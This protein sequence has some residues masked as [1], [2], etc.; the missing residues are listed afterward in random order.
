MYTCIQVYMQD[1]CLTPSLSHPSLTPLSHTPLSCTHPSHS[2]F[3]NQERLSLI[4]RDLP[5]CITQ[6]L[7]HPSDKVLM[8]VSQYN[9]VGVICYSI[10]TY[11]IQ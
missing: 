10:Y 9:E 7:H 5:V 3:E 2:S 11:S 8:A 6:L 1:L 4:N